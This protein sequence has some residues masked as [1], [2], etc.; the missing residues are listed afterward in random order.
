MDKDKEEDRNEETGDEQEE[1]HQNARVVDCVDIPNRR[2]V[3]DHNLTHIP[4]RSWCNHCQ[5]EREDE[6]AHTRGIDRGVTTCRIDHM[7]HTDEDNAEG[8]DRRTGTARGRH[9]AGKTDQCG[10]GQKDWRSARTPSE[11]QRQ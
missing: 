4:F 11:M 1:D 9:D 10:R 3:E 2:E 5:K 6:G 8:R 7:Y